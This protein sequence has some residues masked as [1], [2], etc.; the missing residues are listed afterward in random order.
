MHELIDGKGAFVPLDDVAIAALDDTRRRI[1]AD[2]RDAAIECEAIERE[3]QRANDDVVA[4]VKRIREL[5]AIEATL[6][7]VT[8]IDLLREVQATERRALGL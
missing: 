4:T 3:L 2:V 6:P 8:H 7:K 1:Y 5:E